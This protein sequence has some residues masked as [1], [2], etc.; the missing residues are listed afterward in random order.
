[1][2][3]QVGARVRV[4]NR[5]SFQGQVGTI[6]STNGSILGVMVDDAPIVPLYPTEFEPVSRQRWE[7]RP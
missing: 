2:T 5:G 3:P 6:T 1:M 7:V 4:I